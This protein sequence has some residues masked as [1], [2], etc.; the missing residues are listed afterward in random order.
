VSLGIG[1]TEFRS[2]GEAGKVLLTFDPRGE[3]IEVHD[4]QGA[5]LTSD[6]GVLGGGDDG[7]GGGGTLDFGTALIDVQLVNAGIYPAGSG[8]AKLEPRDDRTEF[9]VEIE[10]VPV[11]NYTLFVG[12]VE[13]GTIMVATLTDGSV[14][15]EIEFRNPVE[16]GKQLLDF[17]PRGQEILVREASTTI[18]SVDFPPQ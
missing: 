15:G 12:G 11:G 16:P 17:D 4:G 5:V 10:D 1:E 18:F 14:Q 8:D 13:R 3:V 2:P 6:G 9:S 7:G